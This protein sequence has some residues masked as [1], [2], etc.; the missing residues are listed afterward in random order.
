MKLV[1]YLCFNINSGRNTKG[2]RDFFLIKGNVNIS[3]WDLALTFY[4]KYLGK[5]EKNMVYNKKTPKLPAEWTNSIHAFSH[6]HRDVNQ[7]KYLK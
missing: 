1:M 6:F 5:N 2:N 3:D 4:C 7:F